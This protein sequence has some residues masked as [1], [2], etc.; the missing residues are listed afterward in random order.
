VDL[1]QLQTLE[2]MRLGV[3]ML[4]R[5][6]SRLVGLTRLAFSGEMMRSVQLPDELLH[7]TNLKVSSLVFRAIAAAG[8][9]QGVHLQHHHSQASSLRSQQ[10]LPAQLGAGLVHA[11]VT[12]LL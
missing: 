10:S 4:P 3:R 6:V 5:S 7:L 1:P 11:S 8:G 2:L 9:L 12:G